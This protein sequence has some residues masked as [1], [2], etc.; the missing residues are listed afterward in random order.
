MTSG[1]HVVGTT[2]MSFV[3]GNTPATKS[4]IVAAD[5]PEQAV[6]LVRRLVSFDGHL[7]VKGTASREIMRK[8]GLAAGQLK[9]M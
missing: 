5:T 1:Y 7:E 3:P 9:P 2:S 8:Y 4:W 6:D